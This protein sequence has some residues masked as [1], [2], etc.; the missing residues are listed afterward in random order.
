[1]ERAVFVVSLEYSPRAVCA[2]LQDM[3]K[4][5]AALRAQSLSKLWQRASWEAT[6][7]AAE[8]TEVLRNALG[9]L[10]AAVDEASLSPLFRRDQILVKGAWLP[11]GH[12]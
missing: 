7:R 2:V 8:S 11:T 12:H 9:D 5:H 4:V 10:E 6:V 3:L 1:M